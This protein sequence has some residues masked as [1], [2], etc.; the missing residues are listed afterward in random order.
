MMLF[1]EW[2]TFSARTARAFLAGDKPSAGEGVDEYR[3]DG[4]ITCST[5]AKHHVDGSK[6]LACSEKIDPGLLAQEVQVI[7]FA[8]VRNFVGRKL[9]W[10][11]YDKCSDGLRPPD[12]AHLIGAGA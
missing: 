2:V 7:G 9:I 12:Y 11:H 6:L 8:D 4:T 10:R 5:V 1:E 3:C